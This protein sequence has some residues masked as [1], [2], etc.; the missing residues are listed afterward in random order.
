MNP[1]G[2]FGKI[3]IKRANDNASMLWLGS[4]KADEMAAVESQHR[5]LFSCCLLQ[6]LLVRNCETGLAGIVGG[7]DVMAKSPQFLNHGE[8]KILIGVKPRHS[9]L[10]VVADLLL[11]FGWMGAVICP[12]IG[13][14]FR[15]K[16]RIAA[17]QI[18]FAHAEIA[19]LH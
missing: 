8:R 4:M 13:E 19:R 14:V 18:G 12:G 6:H 9:S 17:E 10:F 1:G 7:L 3:G 15:P 5:A 11:D 2:E 16:R